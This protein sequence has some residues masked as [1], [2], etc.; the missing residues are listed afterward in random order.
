VNA[1]NPSIPYPILITTL[2]H[3]SPGSLS[4]QDWIFH[5]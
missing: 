4:S 1:H 3:V 2:D 5:A